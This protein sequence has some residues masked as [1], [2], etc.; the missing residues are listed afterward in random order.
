[1]VYRDSLPGGPVAVGAGRDALHVD[2]V[3]GAGR[4]V[5][6][7]GDAAVGDRGRRLV[8][9]LGLRVGL[10]VADGRCVAPQSEVERVVVV[11]RLALPGVSFSVDMASYL[12]EKLVRIAYKVS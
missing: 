5:R 3:A 10:A 4:A 12:S 7:H 1:M 2:E 11:D 8:G 6:G 9:R